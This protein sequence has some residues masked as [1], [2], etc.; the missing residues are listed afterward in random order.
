MKSN[1]GHDI[2]LAYGKICRDFPPPEFGEPFI[3]AFK[4][5]DQREENE[6]K[7]AAYICSLFLSTIKAGFPTDKFHIL[8][9]YI[10]ENYSRFYFDCRMY[11]KIV[12]QI[13]DEALKKVIIIDKALNTVEKECSKNDIE[14][15]LDFYTNR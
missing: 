9:H 1:T 3:S 14:A 11:D 2:M 8:V 6:V 10:H 7:A 12:G 15:A 4:A 13:S 5:L